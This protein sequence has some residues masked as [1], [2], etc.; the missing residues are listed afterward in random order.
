MIPTTVFESPLVTGPIYRSMQCSRSYASKRLDE[1]AY[2][3]FG[4]YSLAICGR[5][6]YQAYTKGERFMPTLTA[7]SAS[8]VLGLSVLSMLCSRD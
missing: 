7:V 4:I 5:Q 1:L 6:C 2:I 3:I 8:T